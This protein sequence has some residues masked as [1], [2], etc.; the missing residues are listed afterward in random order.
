MKVVV[1]VVV[2]REGEWW[3]LSSRTFTFLDPF[4]IQPSTPFLPS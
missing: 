1:V 2:D 4:P 3:T